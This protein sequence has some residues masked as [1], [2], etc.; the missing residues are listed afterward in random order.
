MPLVIPVNLADVTNSFEDLPDG[1]Y[2]GEIERMAYLEPKAAGKFPQIRCQYLV[3]EGDAI[4]KRQSQFLSL[5]PNAMGFVKTFFSKFGLGE[6]PDFQVD[7]DTLDL[8]Y[9]DVTQSTVIFKVGP[10]KKD[11]TRV[12]TELVSVEE[13]G[14]NVDGAPVAAPAPAPAPARRAAA[15][16][17]VAE[18][19]QPEDEPEPEEVAPAAPAP[20]RVPPS[21]TRAAVPAT[22][23]AAT[24][25]RRTLR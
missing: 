21:P 17:P 7:E 3:I 20:R 1:Q 5:S 6:I 14:P 18:V 12:R 13:L 9:P 22:R 4:N 2:L 11:A 23:A 10:D 19:E 24:P 8:I 15:P 25:Q 16:A